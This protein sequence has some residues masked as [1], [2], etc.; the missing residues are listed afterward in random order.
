MS[1]VFFSK[2]FLNTPPPLRQCFVAPRRRSLNSSLSTTIEI[3]IGLCLTTSTINLSLRILNRNVRDGRQLWL[4]EYQRHTCGRSIAL[5][6]NIRSIATKALKDFPKKS[7]SIE[8]A[9]AAIERS[10]KKRNPDF[11]IN[12]GRCVEIKS[13]R[14]VAET[15]PHA[16]ISTITGVLTYSYR[17]AQ[18][19]PNR[20]LK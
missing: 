17:L 15:H 2:K 3:L 19:P 5:L 14:G 4:S 1:L 12:S 18:T 20:G 13:A 10:V 6:A 9:F 11:F 16:T 7:K 8:Q